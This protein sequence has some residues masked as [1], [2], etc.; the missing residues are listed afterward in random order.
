MGERVLKCVCGTCPTCKTRERVRYIR[1]RQ[2][3]FAPS[4]RQEILAQAHNNAERKAAMAAL[5][6]GQPVSLPPPLPRRRRSSEVL[7]EL[8]ATVEKLTNLLSELSA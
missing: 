8:R 7:Q 4:K 2:R 5:L 1:G 3:D 6:A